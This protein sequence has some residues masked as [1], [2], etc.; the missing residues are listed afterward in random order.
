MLFR[1]VVSDSEMP[2][3]NAKKMEGYCQ[4]LLDILQ[5]DVECE[6]YFKLIVGYIISV[7]KEIDI[8]NRKC[9]ERKETANY[10][11]DHIEDIKAYVIN[12]V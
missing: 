9:F 8:D 12:N 3:F 11:I 2:K 4:K 7:G 1:M 6:K 5:N 10:F